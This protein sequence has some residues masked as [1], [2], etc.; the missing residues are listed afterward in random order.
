[1]TKP[2]PT[3]F[4]TTTP[5]TGVFTPFVI[6]SDFDNE[7]TTLPMRPTPPSPDHTPGLYVYP[8]ES[9]DDSSDENLSDTTK[10]LH[11]QSTSTSIVHPSFTR[12]LS[13]SL[14]LASQ[15]GKVILMPLGYRAVMNRWRAASSSTWHPLLSSELPSS[16]CKRSRPPWPS[17]PPLPEHI[18]SLEDNIKASMWNF[19]KHPDP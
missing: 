12:S 18:E 9:G 7:I 15:T 16:S 5:R 19:D 10:S 13:T 17:L 3:P 6:I 8:L 1:M 11:T 14:V 2:R 4:S